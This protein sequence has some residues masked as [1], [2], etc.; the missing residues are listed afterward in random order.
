MLRKGTVD[1]PVITKVAV[2]QDLPTKKARGRP[3]I[4]ETEFVEHFEIQKVDTIKAYFWTGAVEG[5][6]V[7]MVSKAFQAV[8]GN[9]L[10][11]RVVEVMDLAAISESES[12]R[13]RGKE[14]NGLAFC[15]I[16]A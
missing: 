1:I 7:G 2:I 10:D 3:R 13:R 4:V 6:C 8:Y 16:I 9:N 12:M 11:G 5:C 14:L 15:I